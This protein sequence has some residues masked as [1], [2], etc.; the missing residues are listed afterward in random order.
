MCQQWVLGL[1]HFEVHV[2]HVAETGVRVGRSRVAAASGIPGLATAGGF[3]AIIVITA[4]VG[5]GVRRRRSQ[6]SIK[7]VS[8]W[9]N[10]RVG[11]LVAADT[12]Q[13]V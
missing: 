6:K 10:T 13:R 2:R 3:V 11:P 12:R 8:D 1:D 5:P 7:R 9:Q 4:M